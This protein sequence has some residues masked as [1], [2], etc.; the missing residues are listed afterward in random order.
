MLARITPT[1]KTVKPKSNVVSIS[2]GAM[3]SY[4][5][6]ELQRMAET[7]LA[8]IKADSRL[9]TVGY[10]TRESLLKHFE[11]HPY[12]GRVSTIT[13]YGKIREA[14]SYLLNKGEL[15]IPGTTRVKLS[16]PDRVWKQKSTDTKVARGQISGVIRAVID[17]IPRVKPVDLMSV[18]NRWEESRQAWISSLAVAFTEDTK[19]GLIRQEFKRLVREGKL[20]E[21]KDYSYSRTAT[22]TPK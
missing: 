10:F 20:I 11:D 9:S 7:V 17:S 14:V 4:Q 12:F 21:N 1:K 5:Y 8:A 2:S 18:L 22:W 13:R 16:L 6:A 15:I 3:V 19:R